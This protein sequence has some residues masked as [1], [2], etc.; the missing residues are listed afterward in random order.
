MTRLEKLIKLKNLVIVHGQPGELAAGLLP[1]VPEDVRNA[2]ATGT[3]ANVVEALS[4]IDREI[5][6][7]SGAKIEERPMFTWAASAP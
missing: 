3:P 4:W 1:E 6:K 5:L 7:E 2:L